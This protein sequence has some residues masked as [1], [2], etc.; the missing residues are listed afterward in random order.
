MTSLTLLWWRPLLYVSLKTFSAQM[1][2]PQKLAWAKTGQT[3]G[4]RCCK[5]GYDVLGFK[6]RPCLSDAM[7]ERYNKVISWY[8]NRHYESSVKTPVR[9][10]HNRF[11]QWGRREALRI[12][13][14]FDNR[15]RYSISEDFAN[16]FWG[17]LTNSVKRFFKNRSYFGG[18]AVPAKR[19]MVW[20]PQHFALTSPSQLPQEEKASIGA[21]LKLLCSIR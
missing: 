13:G 8:S 9:T 15:P 17:Q 18:L 1:G 16:C 11:F 7:T 21:G 20:P 14:P 12:E 10:S 4:I 6:V 3:L 19:R 2:S 5:Q